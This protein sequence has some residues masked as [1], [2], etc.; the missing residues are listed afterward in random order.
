MTNHPDASYT[1]GM[2]SDETKQPKTLGEPIHYQISLRGEIDQTRIDWFAKL[3][4][5][6]SPAHAAEGLVTILTGKIIDQ[7]HLRG[8]L[9]KLW[10]LNFEV[11][12]VSCVDER[13]EIGE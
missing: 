7:S 6:A 1:D 3:G 12:R 5:D 13:N 10:D 11:I 2:N 9:N 4:L 8:I